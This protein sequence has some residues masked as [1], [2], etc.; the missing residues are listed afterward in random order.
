MMKPAVFA[1][2]ALL[3]LAGTAAGEEKDQIGY[4]G[5]ETCQACHPEVYDAWTSSKHA[6]DFKPEQETFPKCFGCH[7]TGISKEQPG[8]L[9]NFVGCEA[10]HGP[11]EEHIS[12]GGEIKLVSDNSADICGRCHNGNQSGDDIAWMAEYRPGM[13][14]S[15]IKGLKLIPVSPDKTPPFFKDLHPSLT[16]NMWLVSGHAKT[17]DR[18]I[19]VRGNKWEGPITCTAC[20]NPHSST[21]SSQLVMEP[22][23]LCK[24]CHAQGAVLK[25]FG[26]KGIEETRS[27]HTAA[28][29]VACHMTENNHL[30]KM[31]RPDD[32][33]LS[34]SRLDSCSSCHEIKD[35]KMRS[36]QLQD[37]E[38]WYREGMEPVQKNLQIVEEKLK[39]DPNILNEELKSK[40]EDVK[41][42]LSIIMNDGSNGV[43]N[44]D[45]ALEI[46]YLAKKDLKEIIKSIE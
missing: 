14:L 8:A 9:D 10:C 23:E 37:M 2:F 26:A 43:H 40:L 15:D 46:I 31:L 7:T 6:A 19:Q 4:A 42:N 24:S 36:G 35:R 3:L 17:P 22:E 44:L 32:P 33:T 30:M 41:S 28:P 38:A 39:A 20:H 1:V 13:K 11:G 5:S 18:N 12:S 16:Y 45:Y 34:E 27:L 21:N 29:C 25:G